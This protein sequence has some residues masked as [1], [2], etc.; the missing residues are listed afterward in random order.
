MYRRATFA[1]STRKTYITHLKSYVSFCQVMKYNPVPIS[2]LALCR[3]AAFLARRLKYTSLQQYLNIIRILHLEA[4]L[5]NPMENNWLL[6]TLLKG[7]LRLKGNTPVQKLP[8]TP[9]LLLKIKATLDLRNSFHVVFWAACCV[10]FFGMLRKATLIPPSEK[11]FDP[12]KQLTRGDFCV[13]PWGVGVRIRHTKTIQFKERLFVTPLPICRNHPLCPVEAVTH[14]FSQVASQPSH[15]PAFLFLQAGK[16]RC[17]NHT[18]F[19]KQLSQSLQKTGVDPS[20]YSGHSFRRGGASWAHSLG[21]PGEVIQLLGDWKTEAYQSYLATPLPD[22][23]KH[24]QT[25]TSSLPTA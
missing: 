2:L 19:T 14:A 1:E 24:V 8:I 13:Y 4:G 21:I 22:R 5:P 12:T 3:Y 23:L 16:I 9:H 20:Q 6:Q 18:L 7:I 25:M 17:L 10:A 11:A 15:M